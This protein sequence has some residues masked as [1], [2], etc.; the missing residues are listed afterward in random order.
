MPRNSPATIMA[1]YEVCTLARI[2]T[3]TTVAR[4]TR[5]NMTRAPNRS[6]SAPTGM[7][8]TEPTITGTATSSDWAA[9]LSPSR[10]LM[11]GPSGP[12]SAHAQK[13]TMKPAVASARLVAA[14]VLCAPAGTGVPAVVMYVHLTRCLW[15]SCGARGA[16]CPSRAVPRAGRAGVAGRGCGRPRTG[17]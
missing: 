2:T 13:F 4:L 11:P 5:G 10:S 8:P 15:C 7:R 17:A 14:P 9:K 6:V 3:G 16:G 12:S 1:Q